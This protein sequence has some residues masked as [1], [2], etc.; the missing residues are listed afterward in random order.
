MKALEST[1]IPNNYSDRRKEKICHLE[2]NK[3]IK[4]HGENGGI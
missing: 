1:F 3:S 4:F 2:A